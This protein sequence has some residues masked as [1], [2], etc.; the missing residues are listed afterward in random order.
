VILDIFC[1][2]T[3]NPEAKID[4]FAFS[5]PQKVTA[6]LH[7]AIQPSS[8]LTFRSAV[9][10]WQ[11]TAVALLRNTYSSDCCFCCFYFHLLGSPEITSFLGT[12]FRAV[13]TK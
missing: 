11:R 9:E 4:F 2:N 5:Y 1:L 7:C 12:I 8:R 13:V 3:Q 6:L 10:I